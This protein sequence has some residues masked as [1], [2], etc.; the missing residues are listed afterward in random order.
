MQRDWVSCIVV[1]Y[2]GDI[3]TLLTAEVLVS[4]HLLLRKQI[5]F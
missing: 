1:M 3:A 2:H 4:I 5:R